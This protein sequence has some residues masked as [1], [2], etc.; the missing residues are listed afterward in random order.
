MTCF[1][2]TAIGGDLHGKFDMIFYVVCGSHACDF[3]KDTYN[4]VR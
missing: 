2:F 1:C 3:D 4:F